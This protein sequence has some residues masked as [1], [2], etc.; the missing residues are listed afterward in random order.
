MKRNLILLG[1][2]VI[3]T[4]LSFRVESF[5]FLLIAIILLICVILI[6]AGII[7]IFKP[8][9][10]KF[11]RTPL[12]IIGIC[13]VGIIASLFRPY[14]A[15]V[16]EMGNRSEK[17]QYAYE[18]D[19]NDRMQLRSYL[20]GDLEDRDKKRLSQIKQIH[21]Q[22]KKLE[23]IDKFHAAFVYHHSDNSEDYET[24]SQLAT[25]AAE[26]PELQ[27]HYQVQWLRKAAYDRWMVSMG[28]PEKYGTQDQ[29]SIGLE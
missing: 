23:P 11:F 27:D 25:A 4:I 12:A 28:K 29:F 15:A 24:A 19:Q 7:S 16:I 14:D 13:L 9:N 5:E 26:T 21:K 18:T 3:A 1:T 10:P 22:E 20:L 17:L 8:V 6:L 2:V